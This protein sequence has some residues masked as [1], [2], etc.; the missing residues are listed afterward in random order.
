MKGDAKS[1]SFVEDTAVAPEKLSDYIGRFL[2]IIDA[3]EPPP[4]STRT[5]PSAACTCGRSST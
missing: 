2:E 5:P 3:T 4:A 1:I